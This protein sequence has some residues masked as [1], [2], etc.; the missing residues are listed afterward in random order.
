MTPSRKIAEQKNTEHRTK[1]STDHRTGTAQRPR[2]ARR[3]AGDHSKPARPTTKPT[4]QAEVTPAGS[5]RFADVAMISFV[6]ASYALMVFYFVELAS[7]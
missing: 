3:G 7:N 4:A 1:T 2:P 6:V 5:G